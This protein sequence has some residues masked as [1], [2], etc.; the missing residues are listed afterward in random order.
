MESKMPVTK[1]DFKVFISHATTEDAN[2]VTWIASALDNL[3]LKAFV[4]ENY[5]LGGQIR[6]DVIKDKINECP[7]FLAILTKADISSQWVNQEIGYATAVG[8]TLIPVVETDHTGKM[9]E[10]KGFIELNDRIPY[11]RNNPIHLV[12]RIIYS[13][14]GYEG[15]NWKDLIYLSCKCGKEGDAP[16]QY[17][18]S[19]S[20]L[21]QD[22]AQT[23]FNLEFKCSSCN[24]QILV[25][26][27][28][29]HQLT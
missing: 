6:F 24:Q 15:I 7:Y 10:S 2:L 28:D 16:L 14:H 19:L 27:P 26:F 5:Q 9:I 23:P 8:K 25:S 4:Y 18:K 13:I 11:Y 22:P 3:H 17:E 20:I 12:G 29:C 1:E 21:N